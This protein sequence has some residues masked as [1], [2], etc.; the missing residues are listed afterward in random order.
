MHLMS[1]VSLEEAML[2][3]RSNCF[4]SRGVA[5]GETSPLSD[6]CTDYSIYRQ[7]TYIRDPIN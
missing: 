4:E 1:K 2:L 7:S 6:T 3:L 5:F